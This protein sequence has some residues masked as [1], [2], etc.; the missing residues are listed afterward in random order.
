MCTISITL[1]K[2]LNV[3]YDPF[4]TRPALSY[5]H[6]LGISS[7][8]VSTWC[9]GARAFFFLSG[10]SDACSTAASPSSDASSF[11]AGLSESFFAG[12]FTFDFDRLVAEVKDPLLFLGGG[13]E[14][15]TSG[16]NASFSTSSCDSFGCFGPGLGRCD[17][18]DVDAAGRFLTSLGD[19][20]VAEDPSPPTSLVLL[21]LSSSL[22]AV[23]DACRRL[24]D[25]IDAE[26]DDDDDDG[27]MVSRRIFG[28]RWYA[29]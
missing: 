13:G 27:A 25:R 8:S 15:V 11:P 14:G 28:E 1:N 23:D 17:F 19:S 10:A 16:S 5:F 6:S 26:D 29:G 2:T 18:E 12:L 9:R 3:R 7:R 22:A 21:F 4:A 20:N 24:M